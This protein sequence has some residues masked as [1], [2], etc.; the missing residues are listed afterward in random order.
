MRFMIGIIVLFSLLFLFGGLLAIGVVGD[1]QSDKSASV[2][3]HM[4]YASQPITEK[5]SMKQID[6]H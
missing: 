1:D 4:G 2:K 6:D 5:Y 3:Y